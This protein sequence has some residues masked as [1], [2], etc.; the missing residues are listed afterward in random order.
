MHKNQPYTP[1]E[2]LDISTAELRRE[3]DKSIEADQKSGFWKLPYK[4]AA[5]DLKEMTLED[6]LYWAHKSV[7]PVTQMEDGIDPDTVLQRDSSIVSLPNN[8]KKKNAVTFAAGGDLLQ[9]NGLENS[10][11]ILFEKIAGLLFKDISI[12][13]FE[14]PIVATEELVPEVIGDRGAPIECCDREQFDVLTQH[15]GKRFT[16]L[17]T[18]NNHMFDRGVE[19]IENTLKAFDAY[20][21]LDIGTNR[22]PADYGRGKILEMNGIKIGFASATFGLNGHELPKDETYRI[23]VSKLLSK[24]EAPELDLLKRQIDDCKKQKCDFIIASIH[25]GFEFEM[26]PRLRQ[27][28][29]MHEL[30]EYGADAIIGH[31]PHVP[32]PVEYYKTQRDPNRVVPIS[33]SLGSLTWGFRAPHIVLS[34]I[35]NLTITKGEL[36]GKEA[37]YVESAYVTPIFRSV[38]EE[39]GEIHTRL[40]KLDDHLD[41]KSTQH[42]E[43]YIA[44]LKQY[45]DLVLKTHKTKKK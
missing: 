43:E 36:D 42:P 29:S 10:K 26:F 16:V 30:A 6:I 25:S 34:L 22:N 35:Q 5:T 20:G 18:S 31:H 27:I 2:V 44:Q 17:N 12:A 8:F 32:Q 7:K 13:N 14:S 1:A 4:E 41:G 19:G 3:I 28:A 33:Y 11:D 24:S 23:H 38:V 37:T 40:E 45:A 9:A 39:N 21:I 15:K